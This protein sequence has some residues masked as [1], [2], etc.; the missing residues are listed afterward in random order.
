MTFSGKT[1]LKV[2]KT[3]K[4]LHRLCVTLLSEIVENDIAFNLISPALFVD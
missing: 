1:S 4:K 2:Y 3:I